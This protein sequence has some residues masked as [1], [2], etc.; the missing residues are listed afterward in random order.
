MLWSKAQIAT[1]HECWKTS[2]NRRECL[3]LVSKKLPGMP[4]P[5]AWSLV[6]KLS[7]SD[8]DWQITARQKDREREEQRL[9]QERIRQ[10]RL[11]RKDERKKAQEWQDQ[12]R[13][14]RLTLEKSY[15]KLIAEEIGTDFFFCP[16]VRQYMCRLACIF[17]VFSEHDEYG[18]LCEKCGRMDEHIPALERII[19]VK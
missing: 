7:R 5:I 14:L 10:D 6:R 1:L 15:A 11:K 19:G 16:D 18:S 12:R 4:P 8:H 17:R 13:K 2:H 3:A 9:I